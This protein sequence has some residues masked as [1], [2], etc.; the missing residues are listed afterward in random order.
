MKK[1]LS[2]TLLAT[3]GFSANITIVPYGSYITYSNKSIKDDGSIG[4][5]YISYFKFP[6]KL[7]INAGFTNITYKNKYNIPNWNQ[8]DLTTII[9]FYQGANWDI[10]AGIHNIYI[11]QNNNP[12]NYDKVLFGGILY[13]KYGKY[14][15][16][17]DYYH[18]YYDKNFRVNQYTLK[19]GFKTGNKD[20][21]NGIFYTELKM[22]FINSSKKIGV[23]NKNNFTNAE[24]KIQNFKNNFISEIH[25]SI[26]ENAYKV[27]NNGFVVYNLGE[28]YKYTAGFKITYLIDKT[29][30][31]GVGFDT[32]KY[33]T[34]IN[35]NVYTNTYSIFFSKNFF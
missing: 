34:N 30:S 22:N 35:Q 12:D 24:I 23:N 7:E 21:L 10:K 31:I 19:V 13:Y 33:K 32:G 11:N 3:L 16:G 20:D 14:N 5:A 15:M 18:S 28:E 9:H 17:V 6:F 2:I 26:G 27:A 1:L 4:G 25:G 29:T 8:K